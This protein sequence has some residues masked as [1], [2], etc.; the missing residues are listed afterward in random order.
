MN[1]MK[2][3][4]NVLLSIKAILEIID[5]EEDRW[6]NIFEVCCADEAVSKALNNLRNA[7]QEEAGK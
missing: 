4:E 3:N 7:F 6:K 5:A 2:L 1:K